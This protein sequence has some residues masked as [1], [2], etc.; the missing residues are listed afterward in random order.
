M[1]RVLKIIWLALL[2]W[3]LGFTLL[4][5]HSPETEAVT[6]YAV[7]VLAFPSG[8][9]LA[10]AFG[11]FAYALDHLGVRVPGLI[12]IIVFWVAGV[13]LGY[14]Q[15]FVVLPRLIARFRKTKT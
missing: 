6:I 8:W 10:L 3:A 7:M 4:H 12:G 2:V 14:V 15:W 13:L 5:R 1:T 9:L 11:V